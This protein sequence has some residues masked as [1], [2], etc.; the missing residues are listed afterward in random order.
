MSSR[1]LKFRILELIALN[2]L[3]VSGEVC[4]KQV[5]R[6]KGKQLCGRTTKSGDWRAEN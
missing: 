2:W 3:A 4:D 6:R 5:L 1:P